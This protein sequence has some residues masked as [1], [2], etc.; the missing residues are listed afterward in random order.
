MCKG[1]S[2]FATRRTE[3]FTVGPTKTLISINVRSFKSYFNL[4]FCYFTKFMVLV[5]SLL[6]YI[7]SQ[8]RAASFAT[9]SCK[10]LV[11][12]NLV[13][14][15]SRFLDFG[16]RGNEKRSRC[17]GRFLV[18]REI[19]CDIHSWRPLSTRTRRFV[20]FFS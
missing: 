10:W 19:P 14:C 12:L 11:F 2:A 13:L 5:W 16:V 7:F 6:G 20:A 18:S 1:N 15:R 4:K 3:R 8:S 9:C 17:V